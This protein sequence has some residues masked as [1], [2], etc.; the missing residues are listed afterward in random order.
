MEAYRIAQYSHRLSSSIF[1]LDCQNKKV[2][3]LVFIYGYGD[4]VAGF[5]FFGSAFPPNT[6]SFTFDFHKWQRVQNL[7]PML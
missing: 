5:G 7:Y 2:Y 1:G 4:L 6:E 3:L